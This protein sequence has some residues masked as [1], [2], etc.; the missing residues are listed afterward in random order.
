MTAKNE[1][2]KVFRDD[3]P[4]A[5]TA[6]T[7]HGSHAAWLVSVGDRQFGPYYTRADAE[8]VAALILGNGSR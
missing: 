7:P 4:P 6:A 2:A 8:R 1:D 3:S 5:F